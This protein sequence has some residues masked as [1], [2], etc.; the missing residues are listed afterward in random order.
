M[1]PTCAQRLHHTETELERV[2][3]AAE[4]QRAKLVKSALESI[5]YLRR[6][7]AAVAGVHLQH[8][9]SDMAA[10]HKVQTS[11]LLRRAERSG[12]DMISRM[13]QRVDPIDTVPRLNGAA[14]AYASSTAC[15]T[16]LH[17]AKPTTVLGGMRADGAQQQPDYSPSRPRTAVD[18]PSARTFSTASR[19]ALPSS[20]M[21]SGVRVTSASAIGTQPLWP[22]QPAWEQLG[23]SMPSPQR[24]REMQQQQRPSSP[25]MM[26]QPPAA[27]AGPSHRVPRPASACTIAREGMLYA[28]T[29]ASSPLAMARN[30][31]RVAR[32]SPSVDKLQTLSAANGG[33]DAGTPRVAFRVSL[34]VQNL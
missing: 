24:G 28:P 4:E 15:T 22:S 6:H 30:D 7:L 1:W 9:G 26:G 11:G 10:L 8:A 23:A 18:V 33:V 31:L 5:S 21:P 14:A 12:E 25:L 29:S 13:A 27:F 16:Q 32:R 20:A 3:S 17:A 19:Q 34:G 2:V